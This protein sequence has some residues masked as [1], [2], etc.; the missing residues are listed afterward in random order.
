MNF[1]TDYL[2]GQKTDK[3]WA[4]V[5]GYKPTSEADAKRLGEMFAAFRFE[6]AIDDFAIDK[7]AKIVIESLQNAYFEELKD[8]KST[9]ERIEEACWKMKSKMD[10]LLSREE[11]VSNAGIDMEMAIT[12]FKD[13]YLY[14][15]T[16]G[17]SKIFINREDNF[18]DITDGLSDRN[19]SGFL[20]SA[21]LE[22]REDDKFCLATSKAFEHL[23]N[24]EDSLKEL[25]KSK[26]IEKGKLTGAAL[27]MI[28][29]ENQNWVIQK[30]EDSKVQTEEIDESND[31][32]EVYEE[33]EASR[34]KDNTDDDES[35]DFENA[36][37]KTNRSESDDDL[38]IE[39]E[40]NDEEEEDQ[41]EYEEEEVTSEPVMSRIKGTSAMI[42]GKLKNRFKKD[43][44]EEE[45]ES[46]EEYE[47]LD[48]KAPF[49]ERREVLEKNTEEKVNILAKIINSAK[50]I[51][52]G[53][54]GA[55]KNHFKDN[56]KTY[57]HIINTIVSK[58]AGV[59]GSVKSVFEKEIL[60]KNLD[61]RSLNKRRVKRNRY[62]F[63]IGILVILIG[64][65]TV[66]NN[67]QRRLEQSIMT[68]DIET[69][70]TEYGKSVENIR[71]EVQNLQYSA[72][73]DKNA[74]I[75]EINT[76]QSEISTE[77]LELEAND[78]IK[79]KGDYFSDL[80]TLSS[81]LSTQSDE[82]LL[83]ESFN[84]PQVVADLSRQFDD[85]NLSDLEYS[86]GSIF[87]SDE[88]RDV[89]YQM[90]TNLNSNVSIHITEVTSPYILVKSVD[91]GIIVYDKDEDSVIGKFNPNDKES[92][93][94][95][96]NLIPPSV[97]GPE[98]AALYDGN[99]ALYEIHQIHQQIFK[100]ELSGDGYNNG[101]ATFQSQ[102]PPNWK[103]DPELS[104]AVDIEVPY[105]VYV[106]TENLGIRRYLA[107][108]PNTLE[109]DIYVNL[110]DSDFNSLQ[111]AT[112]LDVGLKYMAV[113]DSINKR[114]LLFEIQDNEQKNVR[115][116]K[117]F[118]YRGDD[119]SMF[120][121]IKEIIIVDESLFVLDGNRVVR[122]DI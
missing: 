88:G 4:G 47:E 59:L 110:L 119:S 66:I 96:D 54:I 52:G 72:G 57:A 29:D 51:I 1:K 50:S 55:V 61:R 18:V 115:F 37:E 94:R 93:T 53:V 38:D 62:I 24:I 3:V 6:T 120:N 48:E 69:R 90:G 113:G 105:E 13:K 91:N 98:E 65:Y 73:Q 40:E 92:L 56:K 21:S 74:L 26:L 15:V 16:I 67:N 71:A 31:E 87:A 12:V 107:G 27:M 77:L 104:N 83:V 68:E 2:I 89:I 36:E 11:E 35:V 109:R 80:Q 30:L 78:K 95:Y 118:Q 33:N 5:Y 75:N 99:D 82:L 117:Q 81:T 44:V 70:I 114:V 102:N 7:F 121:D 34:V 101:G 46:E 97:G 85:A 8:Y 14:A 45:E 41:E 103:Q 28:A 20:R 108:G 19:H 32:L 58:I 116:I 122:L 49:T 100:R 111:S 84:D 63:V 25:D 10:L 23:L 76:L 9:L 39:D 64:G 42:L 86:E 43:K 112:A 106:L 60:G 79:N 17:E 22:I